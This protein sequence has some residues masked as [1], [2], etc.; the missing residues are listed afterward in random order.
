MNLLVNGSIF[1]PPE[2]KKLCMMYNPGHCFLA[3]AVDAE[4]LLEAA[5]AEVLLEAVDAEVLLEV[6]DV[7]VLLEVVDKAA[8]LTQEVVDAAVL[9]VRAVVDAA[10]FQIKWMKV[11]AGAVDAVEFQEAAAG[12][13][14]IPKKNDGKNSFCS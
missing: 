2:F 11:Q 5:D 14:S 13:D 10:G 7:V 4:V 12:P 1:Y 3:G 6:V 8:P 9:R